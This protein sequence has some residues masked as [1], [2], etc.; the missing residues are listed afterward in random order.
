[1]KQPQE[2]SGPT[3]SPIQKLTGKLRQRSPIRAWLAARQK[4]AETGSTANLLRTL[5]DSRGSDWKDRAV[6]YQALSE[7]EL[8]PEER[9]RATQILLHALTPTGKADILIPRLGRA[10]AIATAGNAAV[11]PALT[12]LIVNLIKHF[13]IADPIL[14]DNAIGLG[15]YCCFFGALLSIPL[16]LPFCFLRLSVLARKRNA[17]V[18]RTAIASLAQIGSPECRERATA[19]L[20][21]LFAR[22]QHETA[23]LFLNS[24]DKIKG[25]ESPTASRVPT[26]T[27]V[28]KLESKLRKSSPIRAW[29]DRHREN[30]AAE[31]GDT[32]L[33]AL[34]NPNASAWTDRVV[35]YHA[36][37][38]IELTPPERAHAGQ[39]L[40]QSLAPKK[41][42]DA[43]FPQLGASVIL[44][45]IITFLINS[46]VQLYSRY[47]P[48]FL[49]WLLVTPLEMVLAVPLTF[50]G[51]SALDRHRTSRV[52]MAAVTAL[53]QI[54]DPE[55]IVALSRYARRRT[56]SRTE[57]IQAL[58]RILPTV[59]AS[60][61][62]RL[63]SNAYTALT[64]LAQSSDEDLAL[65]ALDALG[66]AGGGSAAEIVER[67]SRD[68]NKSATVREWAAMV[69]P[70]LIARLECE[71]SAA[72]LLR[73]SDK[74]STEHLVRPVYGSIPETTNLLRASQAGAPDGADAS[75][76]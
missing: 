31:S 2:L 57:A 8:S 17:I 33:N 67:I 75:G 47:H 13:Y 41:A 6:G 15:L 25:R 11:W 51:L 65:A 26:P 7:I 61:Y 50:T 40:L 56:A 5:A 45:S 24:Q 10:T 73:P 1:V 74:V 62:G 69:L 55:C 48:D 53:T 43:L 59:D 29:L 63:P 58:K 38:N 21:T 32:L 52:Q 23:T 44:A 64:D 70:V 39:L 42:S 76:Q 60:W 72:S 19:I 20:P 3:Q 28:T 71:T 30:P 46:M 68:P 18:Q 14:V 49:Y 4:N 9:R 35:G 12:L 54:G 37:G 36:L 22:H 16:S 34:E 27:L 66:A